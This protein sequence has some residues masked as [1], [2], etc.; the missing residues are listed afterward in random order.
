MRFRKK[1][2]PNTYIKELIGK[3]LPAKN[4]SFFHTRKEKEVLGTSHSLP[5]QNKFKIRFSVPF[6]PPLILLSRTTTIFK[7]KYNNKPQNPYM[8]F[9]LRRFSHIMN[10]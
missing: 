5:T 9:H 3:N 6:F 7:K 2:S 10:E 8:N 1:N 4:F